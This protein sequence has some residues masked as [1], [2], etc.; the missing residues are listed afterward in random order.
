MSTLQ[1]HEL[2]SVSAYVAATR[3]RACVTVCQLSSTALQLWHEDAVAAN[4]NVGIT[5]D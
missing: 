2:S 1:T 3:V 5:L 4:V